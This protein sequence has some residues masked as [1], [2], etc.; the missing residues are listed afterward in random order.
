MPEISYQVKHKDSLLKWRQ[1]LLGWNSEMNGLP[2]EESSQILITPE[3]N[4]TLTAVE[5]Q[6]LF[7]NYHQMHGELLVFFEQ[8]LMASA[9]F[10]RDHLS[11][12]LKSDLAHFSQEEFYHTRCFRK[13]M[14][15]DKNFLYPKIK[16][17]L[18]P[19]NLN[20]K[21]YIK[22]LKLEPW[23]ILI[24]GAKS[25]IYF[26]QYFKFSLKESNSFY[27]K[28]NQI[29]SADEV[30]HIPFDFQLLNSMLE[31]RSILGHFKFWAM[32]TALILLN[33]FL[34]LSSFWKMVRITL[35]ERSQWSQI[36][37]FC[38]LSY[39][40]LRGPMYAQT[41]KALKVVYLQQS[42]KVFWFLRYSTW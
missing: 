35:P 30:H 41:R 8:C 27:R 6:R 4:K 5:Q 29:H 36:V 1:L 16:F 42:K 10:L 33:Q 7:Y 38:K 24:P 37:I 21:L 32:T 2:Y 25:E 17:L 14:T 3:D 39:Q 18:Q 20:R 13:Y 9:Y 15:A 11:P 34:V 40:Q 22:I 26:L 19:H 12:V 31:S 28:I 23:A